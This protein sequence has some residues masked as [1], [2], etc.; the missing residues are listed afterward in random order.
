MEPDC[1]AG[2]CKSACG[3]GQRFS[4]EACDDGNTYNGDGCSST[5]TIELGFTCADSAPTTLPTSKNLPV[6]VRDFVGL[7]RQKTSTPATDG[8]Y[9]LDFNR[10]LGSG[11]VKMVKTTL[12]TGGKPEWRWLP[13]KSTDVKSSRVISPTRNRSSR[14]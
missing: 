6:I 9:H 7:G 10:H 2:A 3:D 12:S 14:R 4:D 1:S 5:C 13:Y 11:I 8:N